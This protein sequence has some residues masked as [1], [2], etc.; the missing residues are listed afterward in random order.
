LI[1]IFSIAEGIRPAYQ[2]HRR[3][4][5]LIDFISLIALFAA[6]KISRLL[7]GS[8][9]SAAVL[10]SFSAQITFIEIWPSWLR[11]LTAILCADFLIYWIH[12]A[13]HLPSL[14][15]IHAWHHS[16]TE[17]YWFSGFRASCLHTFLYLVPQLLLATTVFHLRFWENVIVF[18]T[19][20]FAQIWAHTSV[21]GSPRWLE[22]IILTPKYHRVHHSTE[23]HGKNYGGFLTVWDRL[24]GTHH[25]PK[26]LSN[27]FAV[28]LGPA[29]FS[30]SQRLRMLIGI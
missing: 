8:W 23:L 11:I 25:S 3:R 16:V 6:S 5:F 26:D 1:V 12:R 29:P 27:D 20:A 14:W 24:F 10:Q 22:W 13:L 30:T 15:R 21:K 17:L 4:E 2:V 19:G 28:G 7:I 18:S 9:S